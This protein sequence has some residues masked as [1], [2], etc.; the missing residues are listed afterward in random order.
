[1]LQ[2]LKIK[3]KF[4]PCQ[5]IKFKVISF[6][7]CDFCFLCGLIVVM[8]FI[9]QGNEISLVIRNDATCVLRFRWQRCGVP[10]NLL[11]YGFSIWLD[12]LG[13]WRKIRKFTDKFIS[14]NLFFFMAYIRQLSGAR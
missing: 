5:L 6:I 2:N 4:R 12:S 14:N 9:S 1:M 7:S 8:K 13:K 10:V 3:N 11:K